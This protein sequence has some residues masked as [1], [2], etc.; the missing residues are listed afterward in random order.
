MDVKVTRRKGQL[1][2]A[3]APGYGDRVDMVD[4]KQ[5]HHWGRWGFGVM[6]LAER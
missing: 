3:E 6:Y 1:V 5:Q 4:G 2:E